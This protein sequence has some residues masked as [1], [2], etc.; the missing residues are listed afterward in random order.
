[1]GAVEF[2]PTPAS[3]DFDSDG[4]RDGHDFLRWQRGLGATGGAATRAN[5]NADNDSDVDAADLTVWRNT[6]GSA[7]VATSEPAAAA[8]GAAVP[9][10]LTPALVDAAMAYQQLLTDAAPRRLLRPRLLRAK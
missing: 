8:Q 9:A 3:A 7:I 4:D 5:G 1:M 10:P 2:Q 6:W